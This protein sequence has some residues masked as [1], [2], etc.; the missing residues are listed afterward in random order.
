MSAQ[1]RDAR[2]RFSR[3]ERLASLRMNA[4][5]NELF[6]GRGSCGSE[7]RTPSGTSP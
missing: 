4:G 3:D 2:G 6:R 1:A 7:S 5:V